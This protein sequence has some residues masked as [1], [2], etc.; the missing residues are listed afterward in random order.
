MGTSLQFYPKLVNV[1]FRLFS[2]TTEVVNSA[3]DRIEF[4][5]ETSG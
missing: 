2:H 5:D 4:V 1:N 3:G